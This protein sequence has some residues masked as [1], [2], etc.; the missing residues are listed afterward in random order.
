MDARGLVL[1]GVLLGLL[2]SAGLTLALVRGGRARRAPL[3]A[4]LVAVLLVTAGGGL[5]WVRMGMG[6]GSPMPLGAAPVPATLTLYAERPD[7]S[8]GGDCAYPHTLVATRA[9]DGSVRWEVTL[10]KGTFFASSP[11]L[12]QNGIVFAS[13][14]NYP[15]A[16]A[17]YVLVAW[18]GRDGAQLWHAGV[19]A[20]CCRGGPWTYVADD[21]L[22]V[23][24]EPSAT[25]DSPPVG[26]LL[27]LRASDG[28]ALGTM[29]LRDNGPP[30]AVAGDMVYDCLPTGATIMALRLRDGAPVWSA[31][32]PGPAAPT[33]PGCSSLRV[34]GGV[35]FASVVA[36]SGGDGELRTQ[37]AALDAASGR[38]LWSRATSTPDP[39]AVGDGL[40]V[41][42]EGDPY[43]PTSIVALRVSDGTLAWRHGGFPPLPPFPGCTRGQGEIPPLTAAI[44]GELVLVGGGGY[45]LWALRADDGSTA[46][47]VSTDR[48]SYGTV[49]VTGGTVF[50]SSR[51]IGCKSIIPLPFPVDEDSHLAA[52]RARDGMPYWQTTLNAIGDLAMDDV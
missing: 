5:A 52:L 51:F 6:G 3:L 18:R 45:T 15:G 29:A 48:R 21:Q 23:L 31:T 8:A 40:V 22:V 32:W 37:L 13:V 46:W 16:A 25:G 24:G 4:A 39:L 11:L 14:S 35:V 50:V 43:Y 9:D 2:A 33:R 49:G 44:G 41:L 34:A 10:P 28:A 36:A 42:R 38:E 17:P 27:R 19:P 47:Q 26:H 30:A 12:V 7:C 1:V 20:P